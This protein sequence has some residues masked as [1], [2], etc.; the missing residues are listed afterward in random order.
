L[1]L[2]ISCARSCSSS[3]MRKD[4]RSAVTFS[5]AGSPRRAEPFPPLILDNLAK[6]VIRPVS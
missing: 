6:R 3:G 1:P 5:P 2:T 4:A